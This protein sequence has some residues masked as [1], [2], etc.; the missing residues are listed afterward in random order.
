MNMTDRKA[1]LGN[2]GIVRAQFRSNLPAK[3]FGAM[4]RIM[5]YPSAV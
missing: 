4:V 1:A 2:S 5:L 3:S